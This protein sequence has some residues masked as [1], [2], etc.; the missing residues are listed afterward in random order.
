[1]AHGIFSNCMS[2]LLILFVHE[3]PPA[4]FPSLNHHPPP[5]I[6]NSPVSLGS[7]LLTLNLAWTLREK[8][9]AIA[10][11]KTKEEEERKKA[12]EERKKAEAEVKAR[13]QG[14]VDL[15]A[16]INLAITKAKA[17]AKFKCRSAATAAAETPD[18]EAATSTNLKPDGKI[19]TSTDATADKSADVNVNE[20][21]VK[22]KQ[23]QKFVPYIPKYLL[24]VHGRKYCMNDAL[25]TRGSVGDPLIV[26]CLAASARKC[27]AR[28][29]ARTMKSIRGD[30]RVAL[31]ERRGAQ[32]VG[33]VE[34]G[35]SEA[36]VVM[37][38]GVVSQLH[39][40]EGSY[41][42]GIDALVAEVVEGMMWM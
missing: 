17:N 26:S 15:L 31:P 14:A 2:F 19:D 13:A 42:D 33:G 24:E 36:A 1:M 10:A 9:R 5:P 32:W 4:L 34:K 38:E 22:P 23:K 21:S 3:P 39:H 30:S 29:M 40:V 7:P 41:P 28:I 16:K 25:V 8:N 37:A 35:E 18:D 12:E 11:A 6:N 20:K 27:Q